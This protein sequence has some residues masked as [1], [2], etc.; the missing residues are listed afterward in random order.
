MIQDRGGKKRVGDDRRRL[1]V[2]VWES[3]KPLKKTRKHASMTCVVQAELMSF[4]LNGCN[5][6]TAIRDLLLQ[7]FTP[8]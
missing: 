5:D 3:R 7:G 1:V 4:L 2:G 8:V 6:C